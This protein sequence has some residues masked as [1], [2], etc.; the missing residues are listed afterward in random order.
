MNRSQA[1][2]MA[3]D[4]NGKTRVITKNELEVLE[5]MWADESLEVRSDASEAI[6][7]QPPPKPAKKPKRPL[8]K[9]QECIKNEHKAFGI[10]KKGSDEYKRL[11]NIYETKYC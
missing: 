10:P 7:S 8:T 6:A 2:G 3:K 9:W 1:V 5:K 4:T 11:R